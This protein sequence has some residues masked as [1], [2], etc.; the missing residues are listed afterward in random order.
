MN[1]SDYKEA[2]CLAIQRG[3]LKVD[4]DPAWDE[5]DLVVIH[6]V[7]QDMIPRVGLAASSLEYNLAFTI[8]IKIYRPKLRFLRDRLTQAAS[9]LHA[10]LADTA[11]GQKVVGCV[12][13]T[14]RHRRRKMPPPQ[15]YADVRFACWDS[16][17]DDAS[18]LT[19][20]RSFAS[21]A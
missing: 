3:G 20:I 10:G 17:A 16:E 6:A 5:L 21:E 15:P 12:I 13:V 18:L 11:A 7:P 1:A 8:A 19:A 2:L 9:E 4:D 14:T